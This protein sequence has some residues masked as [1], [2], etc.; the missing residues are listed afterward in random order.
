LIAAQPQ[1]LLKIAVL[2]S[3][4]VSSVRNLEVGF[5]GHSFLQCHSN[6]ENSK[7]TTNSNQ[8]LEATGISTQRTQ[9]NEVLGVPMLV[10]EFQ[11]SNTIHQLQ[12]APSAP[13]RN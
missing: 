6:S 13:N 10:N 5:L 2:L 1:R 4:R 8:I 7:Y 9:E 12:T 11:T 3:T